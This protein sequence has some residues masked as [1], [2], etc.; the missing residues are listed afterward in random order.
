MAEYCEQCEVLHKQTIC[1]NCG[2]D[3]R[4]FEISTDKYQ[5]SGTLEYFKGCWFDEEDLYEVRG[6]CLYYGDQRIG[7]VCAS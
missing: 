6:D 3:S 5:D 7:G 1:P 2:L 4:V